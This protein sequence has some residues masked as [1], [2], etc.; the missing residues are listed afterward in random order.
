MQRRCAVGLLAAAMVACS[1][2]SAQTQTLKLCGQNI[3]Y[4]PMAPG[5]VSQKGRGLVGVWVGELVALNV[6]YGV[7]YRRCVAFAIE[8]VSDT[9]K[10][11]A[12]WAAGDGAK[13]M[14]TG[15][16]YGV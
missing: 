9:G 8:G 6:P 2:A 15:A 13:N 10:V 11:R 12:K 4:Q 14:Q 7:D 3:E 1:S 16:T 5:A